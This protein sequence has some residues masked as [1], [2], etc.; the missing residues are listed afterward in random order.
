LERLE[1]QLTKKKKN[2][3][4]LDVVELHWYKLR[5]GMVVVKI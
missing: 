3:G 1:K 4:V 5:G 2:P